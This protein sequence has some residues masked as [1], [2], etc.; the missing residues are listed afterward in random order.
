MRTELIEVARVHIALDSP[1]HLSGVDWNRAA[2]DGWLHCANDCFWQVAAM[3]SSTRARS[4]VRNPDW[5]C[6]VT[7][8]NISAITIWKLILLVRKFQIVCM[9]F[10]AFI[11]ISSTLISWHVYFVCDATDRDWWSWVSPWA[12]D[13]MSCSFLVMFTLLL[14]AIQQVSFFP[15]LVISLSFTLTVLVVSCTVWKQLFSFFTS[16]SSLI[17]SFIIVAYLYYASTL[18]VF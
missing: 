4:T 14:L 9:K 11:F 15:S 6:Y 18:Y 17:H 1:L 2:I 7:S 8:P 13:W 10:M 3:N 16:C 12:R 5:F